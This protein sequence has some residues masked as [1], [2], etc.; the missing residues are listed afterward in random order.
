M[1]KF[2]FIVVAIVMLFY[3]SI[4][5]F[6]N[7]KDNNLLKNEAVVNVYFNIPEDEIDVYF[8]LEKGTFDKNKHAVVCS[9]EKN[10]GYMLDYYYNLPIFRTTDGINCKEE[11]SIE[12]H[13]RFNKN[14]VNSYSNMIVRLLNSSANS[15]TAEPS[16]ATIAKKY[17]EININFGK[18]N[19]IVV[20]KKGTSHYCN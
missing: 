19:H 8:D 14:D 3:L 16:S 17:E 2:L 20:S 5:I 11:F 18:I 4:K 15:Y 10:E 1:K 13:R 6:E 9:L 12:K 7:Y